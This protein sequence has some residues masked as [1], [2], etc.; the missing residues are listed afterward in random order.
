VATI[1]PVVEAGSIVIAPN[2]TSLV[3]HGYGFSNIAI[4]DKVM[5]ADG[6]TGVVTSATGTTLVVKDLKGLIAG[7]L[8]VTVTINDVSNGFDVDLGTVS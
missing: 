3:V 1:V 7:P 6:A 4:D 8:S 2:A 5:F